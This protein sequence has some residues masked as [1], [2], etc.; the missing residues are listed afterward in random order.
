[1]A[2]AIREVH[3]RNGPWVSEGGYEYPAVLLAAL[4]ELVDGGPGPLSLDAA[5]G[6][7]R[8]GPGWAT[9]SLAAGAAAAL[10]VR[11]AGEQL[12]PEEATPREEQAEASSTVEAV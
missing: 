5:R 12:V 2:T 9:L 10:A 6:R 4:F 7:V 8:S 3:A 1:M 11:S